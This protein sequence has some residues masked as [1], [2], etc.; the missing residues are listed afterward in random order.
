MFYFYLGV[1]AFF[2]NMDYFV[3]NE[4]S[5]LALNSL[6]FFCTLGFLLR[7]QTGK[8]FFFRAHRIFR[9]FRYIYRIGFRWLRKSV[10]VAAIGQWYVKQFFFSSGFYYRRLWRPLVN[11]FCKETLTHLTQQVAFFFFSATLVSSTRLDKFSSSFLTQGLEQL[12]SAEL[13]EVAE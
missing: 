2:L 3:F 4:E 11:R 6:G 8:V 9:V 1:L 12:S 7:K 5:F 13:Q 10:R